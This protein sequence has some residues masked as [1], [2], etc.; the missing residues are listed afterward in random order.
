[1]NTFNIEKYIKKG[2][3]QL[4][5]ESINDNKK[6]LLYLTLSVGAYVL[7]GNIQFDQSSI[8]KKNIIELEKTLYLNFE[9]D[10]QPDID[11][12][13]SDL[14]SYTY[15]TGVWCYIVYSYIHNK[16]EDFKLRFWS[17]IVLYFVAIFSFP[18]ESYNN[19]DFIP[20]IT[21][22]HANALSITTG[23]VMLCINHNNKSLE[24]VNRFFL[25]V[26]MAMFQV[27]FTSTYVFSEV[28]TLL[29]SLM[30]TVCNIPLTLVE[31]TFD[32]V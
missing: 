2:T 16:L 21:N 15:Q 3:F 11:S 25:P 20:Y 28:V 17:L 10:I 13:Y 31:D 12:V 18:C 19:S 4:L 14:I 27:V 6:D 22:T 5:V 26:I 30:V 7:S 32:A 23:L 24:T 1:M 8:N 29:I 9:T